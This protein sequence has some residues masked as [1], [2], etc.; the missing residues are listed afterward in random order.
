MVDELN[1]LRTE[2]H[3]YF[4]PGLLAFLLL[5]G[6]N[7]LNWLFASKLNVLGLYPRR[8]SGLIGIIFAPILHQNFKHLFFNTIP[9]LAL[10]SVVLGRGLQRFLSVTL[11]ILFLGGF[12][13]WLLG[14]RALHLGASGLVSGYFGYILSTAYF[15]L[16]FT[17]CILAVFAVYYFGSIFLGIFPQSKNISWE[18][19]LWGFLSG[20]LSAYLIYQRGFLGI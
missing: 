9:L 17:T 2:I 5:W 15:D 20:I 19:H 1:R 7:F 11:I 13:V 4:Y 10:G 3:T 16:S 18:S 8:L 6:I 12:M 14:R